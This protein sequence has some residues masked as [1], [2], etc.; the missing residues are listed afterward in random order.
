MAQKTTKTTST[1][2]SNGTRH[3]SAPAPAQPRIV[4][5]T[6]PDIYN[7]ISMWGYFG[8]EILFAI[9]V[10]GWIFCICFAISARNYN[11]RNFARSQFC[12]LIIYII[13]FCLAA[14]FG[15]LETFVGAFMQ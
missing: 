8:Y 13:L 15:V 12:W 6:L 1:K 11:L 9:P 2:T 14:A 10:I 3:K 7:P 5:T 4:E